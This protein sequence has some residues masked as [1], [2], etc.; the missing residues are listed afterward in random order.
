MDSNHA[1]VVAAGKYAQR[2]TVKPSLIPLAGS[3]ATRG[4]Q[5]IVLQ[6]GSSRVLLELGEADQHSLFKVGKIVKTVTC[7][8]HAMHE[9]V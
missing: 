2:H 3:V 9:V 8:F 1:G 6:C 4:D 7:T 5:K